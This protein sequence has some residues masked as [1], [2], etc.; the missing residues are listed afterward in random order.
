MGKAFLL[1]QA[2]DVA[3]VTIDV[4]GRRVNV[5]SSEVL[6]ELRKIVR[7]I[8]E[9]P[10]LK[11]AIILSGK[12][13]GFIA[14]A[15]L[16]E[17]ERAEDASDLSALS[18]QAHGVFDEL[19]ALR[20]PVVAAVHGPCLGGGLELALA[21]TGRVLSDAPLTYLGLPETTLGILPCFGG[22]Q[23]LPRLIGIT[24]AA[25]MMTTGRPV[26]AQE[27]L[28][29]GLADELVPRE[30][31]LNA[32]ERFVRRHAR[33]GLRRRR[34]LQLL[35]ESVSPVRD[36]M[37]RRARAEATRR[38]REFYPAP[39]L[40]LEA[41]EEGLRHG[42]QEGFASE[43]HL[44]GQASISQN[45]RNLMT[46][47]RMREF[48]SRVATAPAER[49]HRAAV[50]G[51]GVM[52]SGIA[53]LL[54]REGIHVRLTDNSFPSL[55]AG[56]RKINADLCAREE[57][58]VCQKGESR[59]ALARVSYD[60]HVRGL[61]Q[62][63][64][65]VEAVPE[66]LGLKR[67]LFKDISGVARSEAILVTNTAS[68]PVSE[69]ASAV[70]Y[71]ERMAGMHFFN[72]VERMRLVE[73]VKAE[74][75]SPDTLLAVSALAKRLGKVPIVVRD[76]PGFIV[77]RLLAPYVNAATRLL[78]EGVPAERIDL[79]FMDFGMPMGALALIDLVGVD[80]AL[81]ISEN[82]HVRLGP[83]MKPS[84][85]LRVLQE[86]GRLGRKTGRGFYRYDRKRRRRPD[87]SLASFLKPHVTGG[88]DLE[89][90]DIV[91][92]VILPMVNEAARCL[93][94][95]IVD[96]PEAIDTA[97]IFG[98]GFPA[99]T[100]GLLRFADTVGVANIVSTLENLSR[101]DAE[102]FL[103]TALLR[104]MAQKGERF[105]SGGLTR[106]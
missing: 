99:F 18:E 19:E 79:A 22:T 95:G 29:L 9:E 73:V 77:N 25:R 72:P 49:M 30:N 60:T 85:L 40:A 71:P 31:L 51:A 12:P 43:E 55:G 98:A 7:G 62:A 48:Y 47:F 87:R 24:P 46:V 54:V 20:I 76:G 68:L 103:P 61:A 41:M 33:P 17:I 50:V 83:R 96:A 105:Y 75:T 2:G 14:G 104:N 39:F 82:L 38:F 28:R 45:A 89:D 13:S 63:D 59:S 66:D 74:K 94:E 37:F 27:S 32:A 86:A 64:L 35:F 101:E 92:R 1:E 36:L 44:A 10:G 4:P 42:A 8:S 69:I 5:L 81:Q 16:S 23:R 56:L 53:S 78:E 91:D 26:S 102:R 21:C 80:I 3:L 6:G 97:L 52:G 57:K 11:G 90:L 100:G 65:I 88:R 34:S 84:G 106:A 93:E 15:D 58:G 67:A 70:A